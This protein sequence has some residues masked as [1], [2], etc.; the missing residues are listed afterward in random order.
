MEK[1]RVV[2]GGGGVIAVAV[3]VLPIIDYYDMRN[4]M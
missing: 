4:K 3:I 1:R 2:E